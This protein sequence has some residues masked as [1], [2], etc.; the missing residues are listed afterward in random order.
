MASPMTDFE[1]DDLCTV[2]FDVGL[3]STTNLNDKQKALFLFLDIFNY[4]QEDGLD[5]YLSNNLYPPFDI[6]PNTNSMR[7]LG[8]HHTAEKFDFIK[9]RFDSN[10]HHQDGETWEEYK[11]RIGILDE[12]N[13]WHNT[14]NR[15]ISDH[16]PYEWIRL[17]YK[18]LSEGLSFE[19]ASR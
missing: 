19:R 16:F 8:L 3:K 11:S 7:E 18:D 9:N 14:L 15:E 1:L 6:R 13:S 10:R 5:V 12:V 17:N 2:L 4:I